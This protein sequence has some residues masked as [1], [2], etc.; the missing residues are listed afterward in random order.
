[1][2]H[3]LAV[4]LLDKCV[5]ERLLLK[6]DAEAIPVQHRDALGRGRAV[7]AMYRHAEPDFDELKNGC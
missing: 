7:I 4:N 1:L 6:R 3:F 5:L 2:K